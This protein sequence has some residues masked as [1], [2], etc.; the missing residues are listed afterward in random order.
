MD[1]GM[2]GRTDADGPALLCSKAFFLFDFSAERLTPPPSLPPLLSVF[3]DTIQG[4]GGAVA[5]LNRTHARMP[6]KRKGRGQYERERERLK[7]FREDTDWNF[8]F[9]FLFPSPSLTCYKRDGRIIQDEYFII[10]T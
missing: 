1:R 10:L 5:I 7:Q 6:I 4:I 3:L 2:D 8:F 9:S